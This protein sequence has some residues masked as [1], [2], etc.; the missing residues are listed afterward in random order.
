MNPAGRGE[1]RVR[2]WP[3]NKALALY[4][5]QG[6]PHI[7][8]LLVSQSAGNKLQRIESKAGAT[9]TGPTAANV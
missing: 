1:V 4:I 5:K 6:D 2:T 8:T 9:A 7:F 3:E